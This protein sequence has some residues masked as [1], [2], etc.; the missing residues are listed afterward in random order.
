MAV[1][2]QATSATSS[3]HSG[4]RV[5]KPSFSC[6]TKH[7][8]GL[9]FQSSASS[10]TQKPPNLSAEFHEKVYKSVRS[11]SKDSKPVQPRMTMMPIGIPHVPYK[12][13]G[14]NTWQ[15]LD[16][17]NALYRERV[18]CITEEITEEFANQ[19]LGTLLYLDSLNDTRRMTVLI[20]CLGGDISPS[21]TLYDTL[22]AMTTPIGTHCIGFAY[23]M[24]ALIL[25]AG[26][27]GYRS[28]TPLAHLVFRS[29]AGAARGKAEEVKIEANELLR[30]RDYMF[31]ELSKNTG[32]PVD[33][34]AKDL[35]QTKLLDAEQ[36]LEY[37]VIDR[38]VRAG[39]TKVGVEPSKNAGLG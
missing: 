15:W 32:Q 3:L 27:K 12:A 26:N 18:I 1:S 17:K 11:W 16:V 6:A 8:V 5:A 36:A 9:K 33:K 10:M 13:P 30:I 4:N 21:M 31:S 38:I 34:I 22:K 20:T 35:R 28:A 29:P 24:A 14:E 25:S 37:G 19:L 2:L 39:K 23:D 7:F